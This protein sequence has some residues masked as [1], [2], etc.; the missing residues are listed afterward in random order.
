[1]KY[2]N[3]TQGEFQIRRNRFVADV[4]I[5]GKTVACHVKNTGRCQELLLPG[6]RA[7]CQHA[8]SL[9]RKTAYTLLAV[10]KQGALVNLDSQAPNIVAV[11]WIQNGGLGWKPTVLRREVQFHDARFDLYYER[12]TRRGF[13]EVKGVTL[14]QDGVALFPDAPTARGAKHMRHL[15]MAIAEGYEAT[16]LFVVQMAG[17]RKFCPNWPQD[18]VFCTAL[19][20]AVASGVQVLAAECTVTPDSLRITNRIP[21]VLEV[22][23]ADQ[24]NG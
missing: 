21:V 20:A 15:Q 11:E 17:V 13:V 16:V 24:P 8:E 23:D 12:G 6:C 19:A 5:A 7:Y 14:E 18:P 10:E 2:S 4:K 3:V 1:M 9:N 22:K